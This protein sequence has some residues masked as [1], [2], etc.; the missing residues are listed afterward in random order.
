MKRAIAAMCVLGL[1]IGACGSSSDDAGEGAADGPCQAKEAGTTWASCTKDSDCFGSF[2][3]QTGKPAPYCH[4][5]GSSQV[6]QGHGITCSK[7]ADC[8]AVLPS[9]AS[10]RGIVGKCQ[11]RSNLDPAVC[12]FNCGSLVICPSGTS[13]RMQPIALADVVSLLRFVVGA[14]TAWPRA[15]TSDPPTC[16][17]VESCSR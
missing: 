3:D 4:V 14:T 9:S 1:V 2:C 13:T 10:S 16:S 7:D 17:R 5:P 8:A 11:G 12:Q 15:S 6:G